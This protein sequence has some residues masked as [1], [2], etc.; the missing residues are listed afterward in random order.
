MTKRE[1]LIAI[2][3]PNLM[4]GCAK[5]VAVNL[6]NGLA[7]RG[8]AVETVLLS[9]SDEF[10]ADLRPEGHVGTNVNSLHRMLLPLVRELEQ[11]RPAALLAHMWPMTLPPCTEFNLLRR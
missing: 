5:R 8:Y 3:L 2:F 9:A 7:Q 6:A 11:V 4:C 1:Y 10:L